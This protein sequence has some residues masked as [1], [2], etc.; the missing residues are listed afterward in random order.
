MSKRN[1]GG[2]VV[3]PGS[4]QALERT[5]RA[6]EAAERAEQALA[7]ARSQ[8]GGGRLR[9]LVLLLAVGA[10][11]AV[12]IRKVT[13][14]DAS[15]PAPQASSASGV[16]ATQA[17]APADSPDASIS[18][19]AVVPAAARNGAQPDLAADDAAQA[20]AGAEDPAS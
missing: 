5:Q 12:V 1:D 11:V 3:E 14:K 20:A 17:P 7:E 13:S 16:S 18:T 4:G 10:V 6:L 15:A 2:T 9:K 19:P 8:K